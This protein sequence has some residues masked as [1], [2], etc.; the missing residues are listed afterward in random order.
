MPKLGLEQLEQV[1][2]IRFRPSFKLDQLKAQTDAGPAAWPNS[3]CPRS[4]W[5]TDVEARSIVLLFIF[6]YFPLVNNKASYV[7]SW[8]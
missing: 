3:L 1:Q 7:K 8:E 5:A 4:I 6:I 2:R